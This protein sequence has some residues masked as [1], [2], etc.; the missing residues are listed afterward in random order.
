MSFFQFRLRTRIFLC[1]GVLIAVLL[2]VAGL[3]SYGLS[4][5]ELQSIGIRL[6][7]DD[8]GTG[9]SALNYLRKFP[10]DKLKIDQSFVRELGGKGESEAI[11]QAVAGLGVNL[12]IT[13]IAEGIETEAQAKILPGAACDEA[14]GYLF[15]QGIAVDEVR[16]L[17]AK[18]RNIALV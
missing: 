1:F 10:F 17:L 13:I 9:Y 6:S 4:V 8:F 2:G 7:M 16:A 5:H 3:G 12:G 15:S 11:V 18:Q 14:Q